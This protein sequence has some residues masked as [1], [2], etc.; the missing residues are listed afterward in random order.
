MRAR[1]AVFVKSATKP[2]G[3]PPST[4]PEVAIAG[5]SNVGKSSLIN[6]MVG[7][8]GLAKTS[9]TPGRTQLLNWFR[10]VPGKGRPLHLVDLPG[11]GYAKVSR[12]V[13]QGWQ[14]M[15]EAYLAQREV[16]CGVVLLV[17]AR[18][19]VREEE[20]E[21]V[22]WLAEME[23][24]VVVTLTKADKLTKSKIRPVRSQA[25]DSLGLG[26]LPLVTSASKG[27]GL[28]ELWRAIFDLVSVE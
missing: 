15:I 28:T 19:G 6:A 5:R 10:V 16:L 13:R 3:Y 11:Y 7:R 23:L 25:R 24:P 18:R 8:Q 22:D 1:E 26:Y 21:L 4:L 9:N 2:K 17:D 27:E 14:P 12:A 20:V